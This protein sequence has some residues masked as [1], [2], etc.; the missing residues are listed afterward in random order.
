[1][2]ARLGKSS[3]HREDFPS[4]LRSESVKLFKE[5]FFLLRCAVT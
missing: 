5:A 4:L 3:R 2:F 1:M